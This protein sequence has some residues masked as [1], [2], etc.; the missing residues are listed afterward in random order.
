M[1]ESRK[2]PKKGW[3]GFVDENKTRYLCRYHHVFAVFSSDKVL[4]SKYETVTD[5]R[6]V[7]FAIKYFNEQLNK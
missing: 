7:E 1:N 2:K 5:K 3:W 6:G 4:G